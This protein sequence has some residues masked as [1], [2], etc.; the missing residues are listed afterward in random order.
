M[1]AA[2]GVTIL[3]AWS[4]QAPASRRTKAAVDLLEDARRESPDTLWPDALRIDWY[5]VQTSAAP[6]G[7]TAV[8]RSR[9]NDG[10]FIGARIMYSDQVTRNGQVV[11][12]AGV[13]SREHYGL[14]PSLTSGQYNAWWVSGEGLPLALSITL[15]D[16]SITTRGSYQREAVNTPAPGN[17]LPEGTSDLMAWRV[18]Q[19]GAD[20]QFQLI[21]NA[22]QTY[23]DMTLFDTFRMRAIEEPGRPAGAPRRVRVSRVGARMGTILEFDKDGTVITRLEDGSAVRTELTEREALL[24]FYPNALTVLYRSVS[25]D[26]RNQ[27]RRLFTAA[28][29]ALPED[30]G[31]AE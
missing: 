30:A 12:G 27:I 31:P 7:W 29:G 25:G 2:L 17:Y 26:L 11:R 16:D 28:D 21:L 19:T 5:L 13:I 10:Q 9:S 4:F 14:S 1:L 23:K 6:A 3:L 15:A 24:K 18:A 22:K 20:A 8:V